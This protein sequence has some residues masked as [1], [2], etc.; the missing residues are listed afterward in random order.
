MA[1]YQSTYTGTQIDEAIG[2]AGTATQAPQAPPTTLSSAQT[3]RGERP[4]KR[5]LPRLA[6]T[7]T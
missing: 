6:T 7:A 2:K 3:A 4:S 5:L 1:N